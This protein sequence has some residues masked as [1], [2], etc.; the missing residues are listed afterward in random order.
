M[1]NKSI[2]P[3]Q[4]NAVVGHSCGRADTNKRHAAQVLSVALAAHARRLPLTPLASKP[5]DLVGLGKN[6]RESRPGGA[7]ALA[8][9]QIN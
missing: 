2:P 8:A 3:I 9:N 5:L 7:G 4:S 1:P 6:T